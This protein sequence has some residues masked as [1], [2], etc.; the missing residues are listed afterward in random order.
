MERGNVGS[1]FKPRISQQQKKV[2]DKSFTHWYVPLGYKV[3]VTHIYI[4][5]HIVAQEE[6]YEKWL[7]IVTFFKKL[8]DGT[9]SIWYYSFSSRF[10][11]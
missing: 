6:V 1:E 5:S 10:Y 9:S 11:S 2:V 3:G 4:L 7:F 8:L